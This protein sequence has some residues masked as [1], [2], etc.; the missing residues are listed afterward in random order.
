MDLWVSVGH[1]EGYTSGYL[2]SADYERIEH[3]IREQVST[4]IL[5]R[6]KGGDNTR[7]RTL[8][9]AAFIARGE[10]P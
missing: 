8:E 6:R 9:F 10:Q 1:A 3:D 7:A 5:G 4:E 2:S